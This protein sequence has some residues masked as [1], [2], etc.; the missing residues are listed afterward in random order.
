MIILIVKGKRSVLSLAV[1]IDGGTDHLVP[2]SPLPLQGLIHEHLYV[3]YYWKC[4]LLNEMMI[5]L[6]TVKNSLDDF[7]SKKCAWQFA[8]FLWMSRPSRTA[9]S[10]AY[11]RSKSGNAFLCGD[12]ICFTVLLYISVWSGIQIGSGDQENRDNFCVHLK[13]HATLDM[14][15]MTK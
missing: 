4:I 8:V 14:G 15:L 5:L 12:G 2:L 13:F 7:G 10:S 1:S 9:V 3:A 11:P 6:G